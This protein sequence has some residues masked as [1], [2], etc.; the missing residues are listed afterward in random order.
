MIP[1]TMT[2]VRSAS[3][4]SFIL[5]DGRQLPACNDGQKKSTP[6]HHANRSRLP[7]RQADQRLG[8]SNSKTTREGAEIF[9][10]FKVRW[11]TLDS[12]SGSNI[13]RRHGSKAE[14]YDGCRPSHAAFG[15]ESLRN[16]RGTAAP[17]SRSSGR[18]RIP[19]RLLGRAVDGWAWA[20]QDAQ[21]LGWRVR[22]E[23]GEADGSG[24]AAG[25]GQAG[26]AVRGQAGKAVKRGRQGDWWGGGLSC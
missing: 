24:R 19:L 26:K 20:A 7:E 12:Q 2:T 10:R 18:V 8:S 25:R 5:R 21:F 14:T 15:A 3:V 1:I 17:S 22:R 9:L 23:E 11:Q 6:Q 4:A 13:S 16:C